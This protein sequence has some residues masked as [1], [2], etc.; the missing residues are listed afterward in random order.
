[1]K[2]TKSEVLHPLVMFLRVVDD[3]VIK[4][5]LE[6]LDESSENVAFFALVPNRAPW[7][8]ENDV[9]RWLRSMLFNPL[10]Y[11]SS[12]R[13]WVTRK[14]LIVRAVGVDPRCFQYVHEVFRDDKEIAIKAVCQNIGQ[15]A[16]VSDRL[17]RCLT[18]C[19]EICSSYFDRN[20]NWYCIDIRTIHKILDKSVPNL[21]DDKDFI[22]ELLHKFGPRMFMIASLR[23]RDDEDVVI[24]TL[25]KDPSFLN[26]VG[27]TCRNNKD[28]IYLCW[29]VDYPIVPMLGVDLRK[30]VGLLRMM[31]INDSINFR[32]VN[33]DLRNDRDFV[34]TALLHDRVTKRENILEH[35]GQNLREDVE[36]MLPYASLIGYN[37]V[38]SFPKLAQDKQFMMIVLERCPF[39]LSNLSENLRDDPEVV[40]HTLKKSKQPC[41]VGSASD[42]LRKDVEFAFEVLEI[43]PDAIQYMWTEV[44]QNRTIRYALRN[45]KN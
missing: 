33:E 31:V 1:M 20:S 40:L 28:I 6:F 14:D 34:K 12:H 43:C 3:D 45:C 39:V 16:Y 9:E 30:D 44:A 41:V 4:Y 36:F 22:M 17:K 5:I 2:R 15:I 29:N 19:G 26:D 32:Y 35:L 24:A 11:F 27:P 13:E 23:L 10:G 18:D 37:V 7:Y 42:R 25:R 8:V 21:V 38:E